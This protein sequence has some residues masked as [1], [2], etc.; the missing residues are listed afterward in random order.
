MLTACPFC[1]STVISMTRC[2]AGDL[3]SSVQDVPFN[4]HLPMCT[5]F[6]CMASSLQLEV[7]RVGPYNN[8]L[9]ARYETTLRECIQSLLISQISTKT[10]ALRCAPAAQ[11]DS[12]DLASLESTAPGTAS[13]PE[14]GFRGSTSNPISDTLTHSTAFSPCSL[15]RICLQLGSPSLR[16]RRSQSLALANH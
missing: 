11:Q 12:T 13:M 5:R 9:G 8:P 3:A 15:S 16:F 14:H 10:A 7:E 2:D 4:R 6:I 1:F